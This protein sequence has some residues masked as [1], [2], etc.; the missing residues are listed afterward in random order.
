MN[1][2]LLRC[3]A[4]A[5]ICT[6]FLC[7]PQI[8]MSQTIDTSKV[9]QL[10]EV[11]ISASRYAESP[12]TVGR[13]VS[14]ITRA[15]I[16]QSVHLSVADLL[17]EEQSVHIV[18]NRQTP[19]SLQQGFIRNANSNHSL[20]MID[21]VR[22]SDPSTVNNAV[23][24]S[25]ISLL[26]VERIEIVR[27]S[28]STLYGSSA[29]GGVVN[30]ITKKN[31]QQGFGLNASTK[32]GTYGSDTFSTLNNL[33]LN[34]AM[35]NGLYVNAGLSQ[36]YSK[37][38]DATVDTAT[39]P[40]AFNPQDRDNFNKLD[41]LAKVGYQ[42][43][44]WDV[45]ASYRREDQTVD[46]D[47]GAF[48][49][50][51]NAQTDFDR[52]LFNYGAA[53]QFSEQFELEYSGAYSNINR[54]FENDSSLV[55]AQGN[56]D[57]TYVETDAEGSLL[58]NELTGQVS[59]N[60]IQASFGLESSIQ[61]MNF[62][63]YV[64]S[65]SQF[66]VFESTTDLDSLDLQESINSAFAHVE[67]NGG[68]LTSSLQPF[69]LTLG[70][71]FAD[72]NEFGTHF[73]YEIN[74]KVWVSDNTMIY[75]AVTTG[76]NAPSLYQLNTPEQ[77]GSFT[78]LGNPNL[79]PEKSISY[80]AGFK[81]F[82]GDNVDFE[83]SLF[84]TIAEDVI[85]YVY[86]WDSN[87]SVPNLTF[88]EYLGDTY[89]NISEQDIKGIEVN[90]NVRPSPKFSYGGRLSVT[91][92]TLAFGPNDI[93]QSYT[94]GNHV[95]LFGNGKF[96]DNKEEIKG[97]TRRPK[98]SALLKASYRPAAS[99]KVSASSKFVGSR[100]D[101]FYSSSLGPFGAQD[102]TQVDGYNLTD[103]HVYYSINSQLSVTGK[104]EN[105]FDANYVEINGYQ[106]RGRGFFLKLS[107]GF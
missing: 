28:H 86:L 52:N 20:V 17:A 39:A 76:Y 33:S 81:Q 34:Y 99:L 9:Y 5:S 72:H 27:G 32:N 93:D 21:G 65:R 78:S 102:R 43:E 104:V 19:G 42:T 63:T 79:K 59:S 23:D 44:T 55:D 100:D 16:E 60:F 31:T 92:S 91:E 83:I 29:I 35:Q 48:N 22:I 77:S 97:L 3:L 101:I 25:E 85:E 6:G 8:A 98:I 54:L 49:D 38:L 58:E 45:F 1:N 12:K 53:Y 15:E 105:I 46:V 67:L 87:T 95:Q 66:G 106:T 69:S 80:E 73:T 88:N 64:Y 74:P 30:I 96:V 70:G 90:L 57:G 50:D 4:V 41:L 24:L 62:R 68:L 11:I 51:S 84:R 36:H 89:I 7:L 47:Q 13:N 103:I 18:G 56:Y 61:K 37:G 10:D 14:V 94:G 2:L 82:L 107:Y 75:G 71:R 26:G 40:G